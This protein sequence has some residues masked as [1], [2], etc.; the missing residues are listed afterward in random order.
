MSTPD[1]SP[2]L[3]AL[4][5]LVGE[6]TVRPTPPPEWGV[7]DLD[8][9]AGTV[10]FEWALGGAHLVAHSH[11]PDPVPDSMTVTAPDGDGYLQHYFDSRGVTRLYRMTLADGVWTLLRTESDVSPLDFAQRFVGEFDADGST[12]V[13]RWEQSHDGGRTWELDF[14][15]TYRR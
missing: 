4:D 8:S 1:R 15:I 9:L 13:G 3:A 2:A 11:T 10:V 5:V 14:A 12:I 6:W 7:T